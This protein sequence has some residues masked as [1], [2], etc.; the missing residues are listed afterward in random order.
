V[1]EGEWKDDQINGLGIMTYRNGKKKIGEWKDGV[2]VRERTFS[3]FERPPKPKLPA[4]LEVANIRF[5][6]SLG[7]NNNLLDPNEKAEI[8]FTLSNQGKGDAYNIIIELK[9]LNAV[10][11]IEYT[12]KQTVSRLSSRK[13]II[14]IIPLRSNAELA[15][16]DANF[17]IK[18]TEAN[19]YDADPFDFSIKTQGKAL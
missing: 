11:G 17:R 1:Y 12:A 2:F 9:A 19:G 7:N 13:E 18:I 14:V 6:D 3:Y 10:T 15:M 16:G 4:V 5:V 8:K